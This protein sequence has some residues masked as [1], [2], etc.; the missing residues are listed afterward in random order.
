MN[1]FLIIGG[2]IAGL[3]AGARLSHLG[4]VT[5][6][7]GESAL[8]YHTSGRSAALYEPTY[9][10]PSTVALNEANGDFFHNG[11]DLLSPRGLMLVGMKGEEAAFDKDAKAM[12]MRPLTVQE[13][14]D[15]VPILDADKIQMAGYH[16][17][18]WDIDTDLLMQR[19]A[20]EIRKNGGQVVTKSQVSEITRTALGWQVQVGDTVHDTRILVN[21]AGAWVDQVAAM[22][23]IAPIGIQ[24]YR[25]SIARVSAPEGHDVNHWPILFGPGEAWYAK[26]DAGCLL[27]SPADE[28]PVDPHDA[29]AEDMTLAEGIAMYEEYVTEPVTRMVANWAGL[30]SFAPDRNL[31]IGADPSDGAFLWMAAQGGYGF[32]TAPAASQLLADI[33]GGTQS[34]IDPQSRAA[35]SPAR[36]G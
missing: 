24:P 20:A 23:G 34:E 22:A 6:L 14:C 7:E 27:V 8:G 25:R 4:R 2:G 19:F 32:Q 11:P 30:R 33:A 21:A 18:A 15:F 3:S 16:A 1:D 28:T 12:S 26:P 36:F 31:V 35:L 29:W 9:G 10:L 17:E 13:A 5:L